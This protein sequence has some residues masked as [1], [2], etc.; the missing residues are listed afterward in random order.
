MAALCGCGRRGLQTQS[1]APTPHSLARAQCSLA[2]FQGLL[3]C[4]A[5]AF[6]SFVLR[7]TES[8]CCA[9]VCV[10]A[11][12][13]PGSF[14]TSQLSSS[15]VCGVPPGVGASLQALLR[16]VW[17]PLPQATGYAVP[18]VTS[19]SPGTVASYGGAIS[20]LGT[21]FGLQQCPG[22]S[23]ASALATQ[24]CVCMIVGRFETNR[25]VCRGCL[26][27]CRRRLKQCSLLSH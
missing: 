1:Q 9:C 13:P 8:P 15:L 20:V 22:A 18:T 10:C 26:R 3:V 25:L 7:V 5:R 12:R 24:V 14:L 17:V 4:L 11:P 6:V 23:F 21:G 16:G 27:R 19:V 2:T